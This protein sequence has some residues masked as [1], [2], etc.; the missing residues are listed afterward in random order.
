MKKLLLLLLPLSVFSQGTWINLQLQTDD[1]GGETTLAIYN[2]NGDTVITGGSLQSLT[3]YNV[4]FNL[5]VDTYIVALSDSYGDGMCGS[6]ANGHLYINNLCQDTLSY[7]YGCDFDSLYVDTL[8]IAACA[9]PVYGCMDL[10]ANNYNP[11]ATSDDGSCIVTNCDTAIESQITI[12]LLLDDY[13]N[14]TRS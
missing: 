1:Y 13:P 10:L 12:V 8:I 9:P 11:F 5:A 4:D 3:L 14:E 2:L 7:I 6:S